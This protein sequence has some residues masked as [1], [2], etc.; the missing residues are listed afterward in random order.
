MAYYKIRNITN[1]LPKR[2]ESKDKVLNIIYNVGFIPKN[3]SLAIGNEM[4]ISCGKL[5]TN[6]HK[7]RAK[8]L[9]TVQE[10]SEND[11]LK[12]QRPKAKK[13]VEPVAVSVKKIEKKPVIVLEPKIEEPIEM[14]VSEPEKPSKKTTKKENQTNKE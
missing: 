14:A 5:P 11:F 7:L 12:N 8:R 1:T 3:Y 9:I 4:I 2:H 6:I 13:Q 10:I